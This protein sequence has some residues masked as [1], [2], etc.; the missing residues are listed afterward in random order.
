[1][2]IEVYISLTWAI[3]TT[4]GNHPPHRDGCLIFASDMALN[5]SG[6]RYF[7]CED[8]NR[9]RARDPYRRG[10][11]ALSVRAA[12]HTGGQSPGACAARVRRGRE[13]ASLAVACRLGGPP[14]ARHR[15]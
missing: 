14:P 8:G 5:G 10:V 11:A 2:W 4:L 6:R 9:R 7:G 1:M 3:G 15:P 12:H 13:A